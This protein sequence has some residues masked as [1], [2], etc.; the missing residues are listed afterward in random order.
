MGHFENLKGAAKAVD[1]AKQNGI[2]IV[3]LALVGF[4]SI[5]SENFLVSNNLMNVA[6][7]VSMLGIAAVGFAFVLLL[8]GIDLSVGSNIT[9][10]NVVCGWFMVNAGMNPVLAIVLTLAM[11]HSSALPTAG[12]LPI[13]K[14]RHLS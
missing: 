1:F 9:L 5:A 6:R 11:P 13:L 2:Y 7:Q 8:G 14:C 12:S 10:V 4:F 3:L